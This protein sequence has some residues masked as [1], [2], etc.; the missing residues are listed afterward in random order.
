MSV[1]E[2]IEFFL[3][4]HFLKENYDAIDDWYHI[5]PIINPPHVRDLSQPGDNVYS[6]ARINPTSKK[7]KP[8]QCLKIRQ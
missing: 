4:R 2:R 3:P 6:R 7:K 8:P 5:R 1:P